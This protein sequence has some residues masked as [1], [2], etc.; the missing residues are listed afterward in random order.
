MNCGAIISIAEF[1]VNCGNDDYY[2]ES[3][4]MWFHHKEVICSVETRIEFKSKSKSQSNEELQTKR[5]TN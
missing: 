2:C 5:D 1:I 3:N 4:F